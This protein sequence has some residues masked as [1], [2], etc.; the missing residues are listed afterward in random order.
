MSDCD[1]QK[2]IKKPTVD[3][4]KKPIADGLLITTIASTTVRIFHALRAA[5]VGQHNALLTSTSL[6]CFMSLPIRKM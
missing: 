5:D 4:A 6:A 3:D 2:N 1:C